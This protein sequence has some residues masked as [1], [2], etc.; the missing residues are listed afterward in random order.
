MLQL[1]IQTRQQPKSLFRFAIMAVVFRIV[2]QNYIFEPLYRVER[3]HSQ[4]T[5]GIGLA[6]VKALVEAIAGEVFVYSAT[7]KGSVFSIGLRSA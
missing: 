6:T 4:D 3:S 5:G 7:G 1:M 2:D